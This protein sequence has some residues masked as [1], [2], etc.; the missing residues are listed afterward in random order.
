MARLQKDLKE[1]VELLLEKKVDFVVVGSYALAFHGHSRFTQDIDFFIGT[2]EEN[3]SK[4]VV[5]VREFGFEALDLTQEHFKNPNMVVQ[6]GSPP[7][8]IDLLTVIDG[9]EFNEVWEGRQYGDLDGLSVPFI[10]R[11]HFLKNK[12]ASGRPKDLADVAEL[13][14]PD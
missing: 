8:R 14:W 2:S 12:R 7:N 4:L 11:D 9:L 3:A 13:E 5:L 6:L 1:F 10:S